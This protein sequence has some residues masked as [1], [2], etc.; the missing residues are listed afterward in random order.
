L[1]KTPNNRLAFGFADVP[2]VVWDPA[3]SYGCTIYVDGRVFKSGKL[4]VERESGGY[5]DVYFIGTMG[6]LQEVVKDKKMHELDWGEVTG[7]ANMF[8]YA[9]LVS[10]LD[11]ISIDPTPSIYPVTFFAVTAPSLIESGIN[12]GYINKMKIQVNVG[13]TDDYLGFD[14]TRVN[15]LVPFVYVRELWAVLLATY[16]IKAEGLILEDPEIQRLVFFNTK[17]LNKVDDVTG[18]FEN[19]FSGTITM[20]EHVPE[21]EVTKFITE[22]AK[23]FNQLVLFDADSLT[24]TF[25]PRQG[26]FDLPRV[27]LPF[28]KVVSYE[29]LFEQQKT[30]SLRYTYDEEER[31]ASRSWQGTSLGWRGSLAGVDG[32]EGSETV[33]SALSTLPMSAHLVGSINYM[34]FTLSGLNEKA[35]GK[36]LIYHG[37]VAIFPPVGVAELSSHPLASCNGV[38]VVSTVQS[39]VWQGAPNTLTANYW[40]A[41]TTR[42]YPAR[43]LKVRMW[44]TLA[45]LLSFRPDRVYVIGPW[46][47]L[48]KKLEYDLSEEESLVDL[49]VLKF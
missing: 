31:A 27:V 40:D 36:L 26:T 18:E 43:T 24:L 15:P 14:D 34:P 30:L 6:I 4:F 8:D 5:F 49:E 11:G 12:H 23:L 10:D 2:E 33:E 37:K 48:V 47:C 45:E 19:V 25:L 13:A 9:E 17:V 7:I 16:G 32:P 44:L 3:T 28:D 20:A 29:M 38:G 22:F 46:R 42:L 1:P 21:W 35:D 41:Y 39:L